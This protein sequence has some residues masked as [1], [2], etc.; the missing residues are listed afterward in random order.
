[1]TLGVQITMADRTQFPALKHFL[2]TGLVFAIVP[3]LLANLLIGIAVGV[4]ELK[5]SFTVSRNYIGALLVTTF[6]IAVVGLCI[7]VGN[8]FVAR[9]L[10]PTLER[11]N[12]VYSTL[13]FALCILALVTIQI[14]DVVD[15]IDS[16]F[17]HQYPVDVVLMISLP[18]I[19][20]L[21]LPSLYYF[22]STRQFLRE[23]A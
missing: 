12:I 4:I 21:A 8:R 16:S 15:N 3:A 14:V 2:I 10:V 1:M 22:L 6:F 17:A 20:M 18:I 9:R 5:F 13:L 23:A 19:T 7:A 11:R